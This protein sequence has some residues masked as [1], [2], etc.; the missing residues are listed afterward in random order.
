M[1]AASPLTWDVIWLVAFGL[2]PIM[3]GLLLRRGS[4]GR[5]GGRR[6]NVSV[7]AV[8]VLAGGG[9]SALPPPNV[10]QVIVYFGPSAR[11]EM[12]F[13]AAAA[14]DGRIIWS[15]PSGEVW[16]IDLSSRGG[17][18]ALYQHGAW[19][20]GNSPFAVGCLAWYRAV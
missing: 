16:G 4:G 3:S 8:A 17:S 11:S 18:M 12:V 20:V 6:V 5:E 10:S 19:F 9:W 13:A 2:I 14:V 15:D 7:L 1:D